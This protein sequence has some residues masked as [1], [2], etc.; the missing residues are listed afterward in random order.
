M[1]GLFGAPSP[2]PGCVGSMRGASHDHAIE[3][4]SP[5][6]ECAVHSPQLPLALRLSSAAHSLP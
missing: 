6:S 2:V 4:R 1:A 3:G 5:T